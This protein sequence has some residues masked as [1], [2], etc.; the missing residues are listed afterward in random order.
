[1]TGRLVLARLWPV[2]AALALLIAGAL[3]LQAYAAQR[4]N[5]RIAI[6]IAAGDAAAGDDDGVDAADA[7]DG[8][9]VSP[10]HARARLA[11]RRAQP[12]EAIPLY[13]KVLA[14][15]PSSA[16]ARGE[17]GVVLL[18]KGDVAGALPHLEAAD[19][20]RETPRSALQLGLARGRAGDAAGAERELRRALALRPGF[21]EAGLALGNLLRRRG[22]L[23]EALAVLRPE[24]ERG[25]NEDRARALVALGS[26]ELAAGRRGDAERAFGRAVEY[27]PARAEIRVGIARAWLSTDDPADVTRA[28]A[29]LE[30]AAQLAP[31]VAA[32]HTALGRARERAGDAAGAAE[33]YDRALRLDP[34]ERLARRRLLR[35]ALQ[36]RDHARARHEAD[37]LVAGAPEDP[38][39]RFLAALVADRDGRLEDARRGYR[40]A[41]A[42]ANGNYPEAWLNLGVLERGA[43]DRAAAQAAYE[44]ALKLRPG[45]AAA[46]LNLGRLHEAARAPRDAEAAYRRAVAGE[47]GYASGWLALGQ[48]LSEEGRTDE[49]VA[50]FR[51]ALAARPGWDSA[52]LS[53][54]VALARA[55]R[56]EEAIAAYRALLARMPRYISAWYDLGLALRA[57]GRGQEARD[58]LARAVALDADHLPSRRALAELDLASGRLDEARAGYREV[59]DR[60]PADRAAR[61]A[62]SRLAGGGR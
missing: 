52:E 28:L 42:L 36:G 10:D 1:V 55:G 62:L 47:A 44:E 30:R 27:A 37:R 49:A 18:R 48:L 4:G 60:A 16:V 34:D 12:A 41:I 17:L 5:D 6:A 40:K 57:A 38:E 22:A 46:W 14:A 20:L 25:S 50:A 31:D 2:L 24:A 13:E 29:V 23:D 7:A 56:H 39:H 51:S 58:A 26:A 8:A 9:P 21:A 43:G 59:L 53:L 32:V 61:A 11:A 35:L 19:R 45:Y 15:A 3:V 33:A 54:A